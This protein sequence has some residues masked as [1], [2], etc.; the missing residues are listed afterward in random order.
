MAAQPEESAQSADLQDPE[1][2][3]KDR[4]AR[5]MESNQRGDELSS[6]SNYTSWE[7]CFHEKVQQRCLNL[8]ETKVRLVQAQKAE[9]AKARRREPGDWLAREWYSEE[10]ETLATR[11]YLLDNLLPTLIPGVENV[12]MEV[13][14]DHVLVSDQEPTRF[15]PINYLGEYLM[16]HNPQYSVPTKPGPYLREMKVVSEE[17]KSLQQGSPSQR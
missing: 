17:L 1:L 3:H 6:P 4:T 10:K 15:N 12:L 2:G 14:R 8:Q 11:I 16:R 13:E 5:E 9:E 7:E